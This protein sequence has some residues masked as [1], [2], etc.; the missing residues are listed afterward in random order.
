L[1]GYLEKGMSLEVL[2]FLQVELLNSFPDLSVTN[3]IQLELPL[4]KVVDC[5]LHLR[6]HSIT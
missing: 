1:F 6:N 2:K 3:H 5:A 4:E